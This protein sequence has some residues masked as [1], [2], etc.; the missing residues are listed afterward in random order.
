MTIQQTT[1][2]VRTIKK[3]M[4]PLLS[5]ARDPNILNAL[6]RYLGESYLIVIQLVLA[7]FPKSFSGVDIRQ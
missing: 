7:A 2:E 3:L 6:A 4:A 1:R 5:E